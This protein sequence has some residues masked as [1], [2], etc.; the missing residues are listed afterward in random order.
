MIVKLIEAP[1]FPIIR[2]A[3]NRGRSKKCKFNN[4]LKPLKD[5]VAGRKT[6]KPNK[7]Q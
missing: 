4:Q 3:E 5:M 7:F 2:S 6:R 1:N